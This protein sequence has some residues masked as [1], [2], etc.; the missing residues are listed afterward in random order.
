VPARVRQ[1]HGAVF[2]FHRDGRGLDRAKESR[3]RRFHMHASGARCA[4]EHAFVRGREGQGEERD[5]E[6]RYTP[7]NVIRVGTATST[8]TPMVIVNGAS[9]VPGD[10]HAAW[11]TQ[12]WRARS[13]HRTPDTFCPRSEETGGT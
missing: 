10:I 9:Y 2:C 1:G 6:R 8:C 5:E 11:A 7:T 3:F 12:S 13:N 4:V